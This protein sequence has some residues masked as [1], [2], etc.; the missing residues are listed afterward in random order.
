MRKA[1]FEFTADEAEAALIH[2]GIEHTRSSIF[3]NEIESGGYSVVGLCL[4][5]RTWMTHKIASLV[6]RYLKSMLP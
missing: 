5:N 1:S 6:R 3:R 2:F 4:G